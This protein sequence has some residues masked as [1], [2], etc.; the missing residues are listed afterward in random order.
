MIQRDPIA[1][2]FHVLGR[3]QS[4]L[5]FAIFPFAW[6]EGRLGTHAHI[7]QA[8]VLQRS[9]WHPILKQGVD[10]NIGPRK[11]FYALIKNTCLHV[12]GGYPVSHV[13]R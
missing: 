1:L 3:G 7:H 8:L 9:E 6:N 4:F 13:D 12:T 10:Q 11:E 5:L 2:Y